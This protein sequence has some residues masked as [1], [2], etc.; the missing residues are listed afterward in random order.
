M[1]S[2]KCNKTL[3]GMSLSIYIHYG[4]LVAKL[5]ALAEAK[6]N[7][8]LSFAPYALSNRQFTAQDQLYTNMK[9]PLK[10]HIS[11][12]NSHITQGKLIC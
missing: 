11:I 7:V 1:Q 6:H 10:Q 9:M 4:S 2:C 8:M 5:R 12:P 3:Q